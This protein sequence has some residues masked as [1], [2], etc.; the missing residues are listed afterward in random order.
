MLG[1]M[2]NWMNEKISNINI[3]VI[4]FGFISA[5]VDNVPLVA[6]AQ[7]MFSMD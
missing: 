7:G 3:V 5:I 6:A 4:S 1:N 2:A